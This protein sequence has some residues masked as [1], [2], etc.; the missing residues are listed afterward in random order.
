MRAS[1]RRLRS[2]FA[3]ANLPAGAYVGRILKGARLSDLPVGPS[4]SSSLFVINLKTAKALGVEVPAKLL[5]LADEGIEQRLHLLRCMSLKLAPS[6]PFWLVRTSLA[7]RHS[8]V[9]GSSAGARGDARWCSDNRA[10]LQNIAGREDPI[11]CRLPSED[12]RALGSVWVALSKSLEN[13]LGQFFPNNCLP[14]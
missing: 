14:F 9:A 8:L 12:S 5:A 7:R 2:N 10:E 4:A 11:L 6:L 3:T 13:Q 1:L